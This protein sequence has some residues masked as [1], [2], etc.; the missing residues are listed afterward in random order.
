VL[1]AVEGLGIAEAR[2]AF[3]RANFHGGL[4]LMPTRNGTPNEAD[5]DA[6]LRMILSGS[7][8]PT[9]DAATCSKLRKSMKAPLRFHT[10]TGRNAI[11]DALTLVNELTT[12]GGGSGPDAVLVF[13][14][15]PSAEDLRLRQRAAPVLFWSRKSEATSPQ[16]LT[17][18]STRHRPGLIAATDIATTVTTLLD[19]SP[20]V[21][22]I[23]DGRAIEITPFEPPAGAGLSDNASSLL[24]ILH[25]SA[26]IWG[27]QAREQKLLPVLPWILAALF[28]LAE[29]A[30]R[31]AIR[32]ATRAAILSAPLALI[33]LVS[34]VPA[35]IADRTYPAWLIYLCATVCTT[36][37]SVTA[38]L[39]RHWEDRLPRLL[40]TAT[41][42]FIALDT[43][44]SGF[45]LSRSPLS[46]SVLEAA[47][48]YGIGNEVSGLFLGAAIVAVGSGQPRAV[49]L[50]WGLTATTVLGAPSLGADAGGLIA[51][52]V[53]FTTLTVT[54]RKKEGATRKRLSVGPLWAG[55]AIIGAVTAFALWDASRPAS[56]RTHVGEAVAS[57][58]EKGSGAITSIAARK[59]RV[60]ARLLT[61][62]PWAVLLYTQIATLLWRYHKRRR[63]GQDVLAPAA[64][65]SVSVT[66]LVTML[67]LFVLNDSG[68]V[69]GAMCGCWCAGGGGVPEADTAPAPPNR[70][71]SE[72]GSSETRSEGPP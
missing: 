17:S 41:A 42:V 11:R 67:T 66:L 9:P 53:A 65:D 70:P 21:R 45:Y 48:F 57:A 38:G 28:V 62:S 27:L 35:P 19:L 24:G 52:L 58:R 56:V 29:H 40:A 26:A 18:P 72:P 5:F 39:N 64:S 3:G 61:T 50:L 1:I 31:A 14:V 32:R 51:A 46:Y 16:V 7:R 55:C 30:P 43:C 20:S 71:A 33:G 4:G 37:V 68:V 54:Q 13:G 60:N 63:Q 59:V 69:A 36:F 12:P 44:T 25:R 47:R 6:G 8:T 23:G 34:L 15:T 2:T 22:R 10:L 49:T